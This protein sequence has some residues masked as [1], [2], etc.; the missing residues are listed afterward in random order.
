M[1]GVAVNE[2]ASRDFAARNGRIEI[3][4]GRHLKSLLPEHL[5]KDM[6]IGGPKLPPGW[7]QS[8]IS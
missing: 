3:I 7:E 2:E 4:E 6:L 5:G 8:N 1:D